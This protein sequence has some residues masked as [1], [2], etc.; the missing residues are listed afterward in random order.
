MV[1]PFDVRDRRLFLSF[2]LDAYRRH[3]LPG[4]IFIVQAL[5]KNKKSHPS[6]AAGTGI[7]LRC[8]PAWRSEKNALFSRTVIRG[9]LLTEKSAPSPILRPGGVSVCPRKSIRSGT[10]RRDH[11]I[12]GSL[13]E[14]RGDLLTLPLRFGCMI[15]RARALVKKN[16]SDLKRWK[17]KGALDRRRRGW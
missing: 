7:F 4:I 12:R 6:N 13:W 15:P 11:S 1:S 14:R 5:L 17:E 2:L 16:F 9:S 10:F 8:H 3:R